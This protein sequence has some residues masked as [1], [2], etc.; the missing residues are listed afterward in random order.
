LYGTLIIFGFITSVRTHF[1][2]WPSVDLFF[3]ASPRIFEC[4]TRLWEVLTIHFGSQA[5]VV[6]LAAHISSL[7]S[8]SL[9]YAIWALLIHWDF[10]INLR[11]WLA[12]FKVSSNN[13]S[14]I[15]ISPLSISA[16]FYFWS[17]RSAMNPF[18]PLVDEFKGKFCFFLPIFD[19]TCTHFRW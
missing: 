17:F 18:L 14:P 15:F 7:D 6:V 5:Y 10:P 4:S 8:V 19:L 11:I 13:F 12:I 1:V 16:W 9:W 3:G 2:T